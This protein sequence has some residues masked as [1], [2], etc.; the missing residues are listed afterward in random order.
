MV[1]ERIG[2]KGGEGNRVG[3]GKRVKEGLLFPA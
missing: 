1:G 3:G 2:W